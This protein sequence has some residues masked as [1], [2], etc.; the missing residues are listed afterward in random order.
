MQGIAGIH[1]E[2]REGPGTSMIYHYSSPSGGVMF[3]LSCE[4]GHLDDALHRALYS[5]TMRHMPPQQLAA[6]LEEADREVETQPASPEDRPR[7]LEVEVPLPTPAT[8][9]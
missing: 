1:V 2:S 9:D 7:L 8:S 3:S 4:Q 5:A 6:A